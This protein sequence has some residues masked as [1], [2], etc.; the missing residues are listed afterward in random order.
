MITRNIL[1]NEF[2]KSH[3]I[4]AIHARVVYLPKACQLLIFTCQRANKRADVPMCQR[5][6]S[7]S[8]QRANVQRRANF[9]SF[10]KRRAIFFKFACQKLFN[11]FSRELHFLYTKYIYILYIFYMNIFF[12]L[13]LQAVCK[14]PIYKS[15]NQII[16]HKNLRNHVSSQQNKQSTGSG[17][18]LG[19]RV[20]LG[21]Y[22]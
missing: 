22:Q 5:R 17:Q 1:V 20:C 3:A 8:S 16:M 7:F 9:L 11:Y 6:V 10:G 18:S 19:V 14:K 12:Y 2:A 15:M 21:M 4:R 13:N